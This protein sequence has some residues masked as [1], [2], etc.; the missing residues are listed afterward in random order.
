MCTG[1]CGV[2]DQQGLAVLSASRLGIMPR[3]H[4]RSEYLDLPDRP[5]SATKLDQVFGRGSTRRKGT[6]ARPLVDHTRSTQDPSRPLQD[7]L[8][9]H[10]PTSTGPQLDLRDPFPM[11]SRSTRPARPF[12]DLYPTST[13]PI[14]DLYPTMYYRARSL[15]DSSIL[16]FGVQLTTDYRRS[17]IMEVEQQALYICWLEV[18]VQLATILAEKEEQEEAHAELQRREIRRRRVQRRKAIWCRQWLAR[19]P[20][21]GDLLSSSALSSM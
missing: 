4:R 10:I 7:H 8:P 18:A 21:C 19:R 17:N 1:Y 20:L 15:H 16:L 13:R 5:N 14:R 9:T 6:S 3:S 12:L 2:H 11:F